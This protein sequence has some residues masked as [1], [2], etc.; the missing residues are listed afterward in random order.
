MIFSLWVIFNCLLK[1]DELLRCNNS[2]YVLTKLEGIN[3]SSVSILKIF[4]KLNDM[5]F[6]IHYYEK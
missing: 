1:K 2:N 5:I 4:M 6:Y 3:E